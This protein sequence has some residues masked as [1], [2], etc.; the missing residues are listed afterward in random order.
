MLTLVTTLLLPAPAVSE[1]V[2]IGYFG[3]AECTGQRVQTTS[4][5][6]Q[7]IKLLH[8]VLYP[9]SAADQ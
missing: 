2:N 4:I 8:W 9:T 7:E 1:H 3:K 5:E 6:Q